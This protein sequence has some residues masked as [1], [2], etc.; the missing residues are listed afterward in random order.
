MIRGLQKATWTTGLGSRRRCR[1]LIWGNAGP[2]TGIRSLGT[3]G[4][5]VFPVQRVAEPESESAEPAGRP[6]VNTSVNTSVKSSVNSSVSSPAA[7]LPSVFKLRE[8]SFRE[9]E[10]TLIGDRY[11]NIE[12]I[13]RGRF[14]LVRL[15]Q[16]VLDH[17]R[18]VALKYVNKSANN[19]ILEN[20]V[21]ILGKMA[22]LSETN[23]EFLRRFTVPI[24]IVEDG[25]Q[26]VFVFE[27]V[28]GGDLFDRIMLKGFV[29]EHD[30]KPTMRF[31]VDSLA[32]LHNNG[33][34]HRD[35][36]PENVLFRHLNSKV[37]ENDWVNVEPVL[38]DF[39]LS[40]LE[41]QCDLVEPPAGT[42]GYAAPEILNSSGKVSSA[43]DIWSLGVMLYASLAG[44]L[45]FPASTDGTTTLE[46]HLQE[47]HRGPTFERERWNS[48]SPEVQD[49]ISQMLHYSQYNRITID[50]IKAHAWFDEN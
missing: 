1:P 35:I 18:K 2:R 9:P 44:E 24:N 20:E 21:S 48:L 33:I 17:D 41:G 14:G 3:Q 6:S 37:T 50:Q 34:V 31:V 10:S 49:L 4:F 7:G 45:P 46:N 16:D 28:K 36:K 27:Y 13:G 39:G 15:G 38:C 8:R 47:A 19:K 32:L 5:A 25:D 26:L 29:G 43:S 22:E 23:V 40:H 30:L 11:E 12:L 42:F